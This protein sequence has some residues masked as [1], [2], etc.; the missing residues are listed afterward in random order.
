MNRTLLGSMYREIKPRFLALHIGLLSLFS[1]LFAPNS[2]SKRVCGKHPDE[3]AQ[4]N[5][6]GC[7]SPCWEQVCGRARVTVVSVVVRWVVYLL[8]QT[9]FTMP[10]IA[11]DGPS[12]KRVPGK[13][14]DELAQSNGAGS[15]CATRG[16]F[17]GWEANPEGGIF[18]S[19]AT[20]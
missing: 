11:P 8:N 13:H 19:T 17:H 16:L 15:Q 2:R 3:L 6:V 18:T 12:S 5:G 4:S 14:P 1:S 10:A 20:N 7:A 9:G